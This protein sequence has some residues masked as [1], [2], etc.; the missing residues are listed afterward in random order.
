MKAIIIKP[1][2]VNIQY[3]EAYFGDIFKFEKKLK[4]LRTTTLNVPLKSPNTIQDILKSDPTP[5]PN[6]I[7]EYI[8]I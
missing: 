5:N 7:D 6:I 3:L 8:I 4:I 2:T 1:T